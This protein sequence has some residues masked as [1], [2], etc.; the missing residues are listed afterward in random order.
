[1][2]VHVIEEIVFLC[3]YNPTMLSLVCTKLA[4][5]FYET[6][7]ALGSLLAF[8]TKARGNT[9]STLFLPQFPIPVCYMAPLLS[10]NVIPYLCLPY[11]DVLAEVFEVRHS[12]EALRYRP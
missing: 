2:I 9:V 12:P 11:H 3:L 6:D 10:Y 1:M 7:N 4:L 8:K 5:H